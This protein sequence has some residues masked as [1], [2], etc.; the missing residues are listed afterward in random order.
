VKEWIENNVNPTKVMESFLWY[1]FSKVS[2]EDMI[3][4]LK[5]F[6]ELFEKSMIDDEMEWIEKRNEKPEIKQQYKDEVQKEV[7]KETDLNM[8]HIEKIIKELNLDK[9]SWKKMIEIFNGDE[10]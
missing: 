8:K 1:T 4:N 9:N 2:D 6:R 3:H 10:V 5:N 7:E